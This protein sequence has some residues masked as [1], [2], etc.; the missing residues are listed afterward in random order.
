MV[1]KFDFYD[2]KRFYKRVGYNWYHYSYCEDDWIGD[3]QEDLASFLSDHEYFELGLQVIKVRIKKWK[4]IRSKIEKMINSGNAYFI[5][6]TWSNDSMEHF[7]Q[8]SR[9]M[10]VQKTLSKYNDYI[11]NIDYG[12]QT[13]REHYHA[14]IQEDNL[15][16]NSNTFNWPYGFYNI[17]TIK[18]GSQ[19]ALATYILKFTNHTT[20][21]TVRGSK[22]IFKRLCRESR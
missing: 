10:L 21:E 7:S 18:P 13:E 22:P 8:D 15:D 17:Q 16:V 5:T 6:L 20:K 11:A 2:L 9:R 1:N 14:I 3:D 12:S 19:E 4:R